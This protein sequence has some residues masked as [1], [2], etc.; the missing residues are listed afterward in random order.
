[1]LQVRII[2]CESTIGLEKEVNEKL[3]MLEKHCAYKIKEIKYAVHPET[4]YNVP[5][6]SAMIIFEVNDEDKQGGD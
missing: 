3:K 1:M 6:Y 4:R 5:S 2:D